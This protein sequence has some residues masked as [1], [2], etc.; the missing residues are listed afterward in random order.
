M[1]RSTFHLEPAPPYSLDLT[2]RTLRRRPDDAV[3]GLIDFQL[4]LDR[5]GEVGCLQ[6]RT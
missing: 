2:V 1:S 3:R 4:L 5:P 6:G